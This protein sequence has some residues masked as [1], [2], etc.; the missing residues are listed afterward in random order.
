M[1][2]RD[3]L[4][5]LNHHNSWFRRFCNKFVWIANFTQFILRKWCDTRE[6]KNWRTKQLVLVYV[7]ILKCAC[8]KAI[9]VAWI[10]RRH[11]SV[12][13]ATMYRPSARCC[14]TPSTS[15][16]DPWWVDWMIISLKDKHYNNPPLLVGQSATFPRPQRILKYGLFVFN[17]IW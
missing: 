16:S 4:P 3:C 5:T 1:Q 9:A 12:C 17:L 11:D 8:W 6:M 15:A 2:M 7:R 10:K 13:K 14:G